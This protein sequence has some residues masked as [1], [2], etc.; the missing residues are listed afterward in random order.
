M[1]KYYITSNTG[2]SLGESGR[3]YSITFIC[4]IAVFVEGRLLGTIFRTSVH[5]PNGTLIALYVCGNS[6]HIILRIAM[7]PYS[8]SHEAFEGPAAL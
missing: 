3:L 8:Y 2:S 7:R 5:F 4:T 6:L 1:L